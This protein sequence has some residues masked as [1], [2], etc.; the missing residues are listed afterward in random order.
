MENV[1]NQCKI[2]GVHDNKFQVR[3]AQI[4][5]LKTVYSMIVE[6]AEDL[7]ADVSKDVILTEDQFM[8]GFQ[9]GY[10]QVVVVEKKN[11]ETEDK[12][13][14]DVVIKLDAHLDES[15]I[16]KE[17]DSFVGYA[18]YVYGYETWHGRTL[19][20]D[21]IYIRQMY[22]KTG[23]GTYL[24][25]ILAKIGLENECKSLKWQCLD[26]NTKALNFYFNKLKAT[27]DVQE[28]KGKKFKLVNIEMEEDDMRDLAANVWKRS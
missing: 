4:S 9:E 10:F 17:N 28:I 27:E 15:L 11:L 23:L 7:K 6:L 1:L 16:G 25:S 26:W 20:L 14:S 3:N 19:C 21:D 12:L 22:R 13:P 8:H 2:L 24:I 5:D 18:L